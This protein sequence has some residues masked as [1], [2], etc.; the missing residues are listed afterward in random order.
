MCKEQICRK[1][2]LL[3]CL[4]STALFAAEKP[5]TIPEVTS[6]AP[7]AGVLKV[8][9][10]FKKI[11]ETKIDKSAKEL[12][13]EGY[14]IEIGSRKIKIRAATRTGLYYGAQTVKQMLKTA[15]GEL[16]QGG[17]TDVPKYRVRGFVFDVGRLPV[18]IEFL[19]EVVDIMSM[20]KMND[21]QL[22]L[23]DN[24][25]W[26]EDYVKQGK[27]PFK[28]SYAAFRLESK[29]KDLTAKDVNYTKKAF[30]ELV[31]YAKGKCVNIVPEFDMPGH[32][33]AL[34]RVRPD[35][36][37]QGPMPHHPDR[38]C[39]MMDAAKPETLKFAGEVFDE[40]LLA[41]KGAKRAVFADCP[42]VH[43]GSDEFFGGAEDYRRFVDGLLGHVQGRGYTPRVWGSLR[44][45]PGKTPVRSKGVQMNIWSMDWGR[46]KESIDL[47]YDIIN[48]LDRNLYFVPTANYYRMDRNLKG[49]W[50]NWQ[51]NVIGPDTIDPGD[52]HLLGA[53]WACWNDMIGPK[54]N[55]YT[56]KDLKATIADV[57]GVLSEKMWRGERPP[58]PFAAHQELMKT[59]CRPTAE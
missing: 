53:S 30:A 55:G 51:P 58:R 45:K 5:P 32:A 39:E 57:C 59:L 37:Y 12:G 26:H 48:T 44:R 54:H 34:T 22:H 47:G 56:Y 31:A 20:Y 17:I 21:L 4:M 24:Y 29:I 9:E 23:N 27:D 49:L 10:N 35:L 8:P 13:N 1:L 43:I 42:V 11:V 14:K 16:P 33:L 46:A 28:E 2:L 36:I 40:Y 38:R 41:E 25:I 52:P 50:E 19:Y 7:G 18:P 15:G 3:S 6:W